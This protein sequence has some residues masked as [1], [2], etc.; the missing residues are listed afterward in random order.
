MAAAFAV[1]KEKAI[2]HVKYSMK[3]PKLQI[4]RGAYFLFE[5]PAHATSWELPCI[6]E[7]MKMTGV[8]AVVGDMCTYGLTTLGEDRKTMV[9]AKKLTQF[10]GNGHFILSELSTRCDKT[11]THQP[12]MGGRASKAQEY[13]HEL[14]CAIEA[15]PNRSSMIAVARCAWA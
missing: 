11:H 6:K 12:L 13:S 14:F 10:M 7:V 5:H 1:E 4:S 2:A 9:P 15:L 8:E 3:L